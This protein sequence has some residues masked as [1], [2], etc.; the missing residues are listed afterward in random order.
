MF[1]T[2]R[3]EIIVDGEILDADASPCVALVPVAQ[4]VRWSPKAAMARPDPVFVTHLIAFY[5]AGVG[6]AQEGV[7][8]Y[9]WVG[10]F[11]VFVISHGPSAYRW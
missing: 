7:V 8:F 2:E 10:I 11:I 9:I 3:P 6:G 1:D 4:T 5:L